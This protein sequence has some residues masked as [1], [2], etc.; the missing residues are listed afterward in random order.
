M[1]DVQSTPAESVKYLIV[2]RIF[3][4]AFSAAVIVAGAPLLLLIA[5]LVRMSS[6]GPVLFRQERVGLN[7]RTFTMY[8]FRT[9]K[10]G[11]TQESETR[12]T[13]ENDPRRT[14]IGSFLRKTSLD[15]LPQFFNVLR[16]HMSVVGP[17]PE[18][19]H[20]VKQFFLDYRRYN[21]RHRLKAGI[22]GLAQVQGFRGD[23]PIDKRLECDL[24]YLRNWSFMLDLKIIGMTV[25][26]G[27]LNKNAY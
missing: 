17:R 3:D 12:W 18:R 5:A 27:L 1:L 21:Q 9:M 15:E 22:T 14:A 8:K 19:P 20:F 24:A 26:S 25:F 11:D 4:V 16:G 7:G 13:V 10:V 23:T 2:K 6:R